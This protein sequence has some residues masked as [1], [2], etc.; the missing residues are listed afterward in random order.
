M[1]NNF[2]YSYATD[3]LNNSQ[4]YSYDP[5]LCALRDT[6]SDFYENYS[7][8][9][10]LYLVPEIQ[11]PLQKFELIIALLGLQKN[12]SSKSLVIGVH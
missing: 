12:A 5:S 2:R 9:K 8:H 1:L 3:K 11:V 10:S 7:L 6:P 4:T